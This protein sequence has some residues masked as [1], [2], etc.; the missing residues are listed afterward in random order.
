MTSD[1]TQALVSIASVVI[2][3][4]TGGVT[5]AIVI[6]KYKEKVDSL[7]RSREKLENKLDICRSEIDTLKE[8]KTN[9]QKYIDSKIYQ[10]NSPLS[11]TDYGK[12]LIKDSGFETIFDQHKDDLAE[13]LGKLDPKTA[14]DVQEVSRS[15]MDSQAEYAPFAP[16]KDYAYRTGSDLNLIL[17]AGAILLRDYYLEK[18]P[19][20]DT[21][22]SY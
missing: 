3:A 2:A 10:S 17:R 18:H 20:I 5:A 12:K 22:K 21:S 11:L 1:Q 4:L 14:Y 6:G 19:E 9:A 15:F 7:E 16:I 13:M 8:F